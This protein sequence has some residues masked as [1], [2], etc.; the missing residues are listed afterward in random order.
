MGGK[1]IY[2]KERKV[3][4]FMKIYPRYYYPSIYHIPYRQLYDQGFRGIVFDIDNT[5]VA[6]DR[7]MPTAE[8][9][10]LVALLRRKGFSIVL[11]SNNTKRR[12]RPFA[13]GIRL[14]SVFSAIKPLPFG[15]KKGLTILG[16]KPEETVIIGDQ[17]FTDVIAGNL[18]G[19]CT[20]LVQPI[21][22]Q[23][24]FYTKIKR[25]LEKK[26]LEYAHITNSED[27]WREDE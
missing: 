24:A 12:V 26:L 7:K 8:V 1:I 11:V 10:E 23:E 6:Y 17:L 14:R 22:E 9:A 3:E 18:L 15:L 13:K 27:K 25:K 2:Y 4:V 16:T 19:L 5:L 21:Q 20:I